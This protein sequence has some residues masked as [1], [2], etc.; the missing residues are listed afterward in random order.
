N[1]PDNDAEADGRDQDWYSKV[2]AWIKFVATADSDFGPAKAVIK[3]KD[4]KEYQTRNE[5][6]LGPNI[7]SPTNNLTTPNYQIAGTATPNDT[8]DDIYLV[9]GANGVLDTTAAT[10]A[11]VGDDVTV[12]YDNY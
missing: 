5:D 9:A 10:A 4:L 11:I 12:A 3:I 8:S 2:E 1:I 6:N 7:L